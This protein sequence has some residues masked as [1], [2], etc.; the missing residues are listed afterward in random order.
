VGAGTPLQ[1]VQE[2]LARHKKQVALASPWTDTTVGAL[3]AANE[4]APLRTRYGAIRDNVLC[5]TVA[6]ADGRVI[7]T[8]RP[9]MKN[10]AG[11]DLTKAFVGSRGTLGLLI[12]VSLKVVAQPRARRTLLVPVEQVEQG[13]RYGTRLLNLTLNASAVLLCKGVSDP[14][15]PESAYVLVYTAEGIPEDVEAELEQVSALLREEQAPEPIESSEITGTSLWAMLLRQTTP[16]EMIVR[17]GVPVKDI[18]AYGTS[19]M[20]AED[21]CVIDLGSGFLYTWRECAT[22]DAATSWLESLRQPALGLGGYAVVVRV[23]ERLATT[24]DRWG[25]QPDG[26]QIMKRLKT[27]W[28]PRGILNPGVF[29]I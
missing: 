12:D 29:L 3:V 7:R 10:V 11:Y 27:Q 13:L 22:V 20:P 19:F 16:D 2:F 21:N 15:F 23:P 6:L 26:L 9:I 25:Y 5:A 18:T 28:D 1:E 17:A 8:G 4:N 14:T 24:I